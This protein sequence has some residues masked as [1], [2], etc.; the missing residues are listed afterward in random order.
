MD[1]KQT[2]EYIE[3]IYQLF[4]KEGINDSFFILNL[5]IYFLYLRRLDAL[6]TFDTSQKVS[7]FVDE[8]I[9]KCKWNY[10][11]GLDAYQFA[12]N[13]ITV[14]IPF[15]KQQVVGS[16]PLLF[17][18]Y[19]RVPKEKKVKDGSVYY[20]LFHLV[21]DLLNSCDGTIGESIPI[22]YL[23]YIYEELINHYHTT[24]DKGHLFVPHH[25]AR[26]MCELAD[27]KVE[28]SIYTPDLGTGDLLV[29]AYNT[30]VSNNL[31]EGSKD[32]DE[33][34]F[35][36]G[37]VSN[38]LLTREQLNNLVLEGNQT[39]DE[40]MFL[41]VMNIY[42]HGI[43]LVHN[44]TTQNLL[45]SDFDPV[46]RKYTKIIA[47]PLIG[48]LLKGQ[49]VDKELK[50]RVG[51]NKSA[52]YIDRCL[53]QLGEGGRLVF[54]TPEGFLF[55]HDSK[56]S[57]YREHLLDSYT[58]EAVISLPNGVLPNTSIKTSIL[59]ISKKSCPPNGTV[60]LCELKNDGYSLNAK[61]LRNSES[62][63]PLLID[64]FKNRAEESN[65]LMDCFKVSQIEMRRHQAAWVVNFY[66][67]YHKPNVEYK[68]PQDI[69]SELKKMEKGIILELDN[70]SN[71][72]IS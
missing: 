45:S 43:N 41:T 56:T 48:S 44:F 57:R 28:D 52:M 54:L 64:N 72:L 71:L 6:G 1:R 61:R 31:S 29:T 19:N 55:A 25:I 60:W 12:D 37:E 7:N 2:K 67:E 18:F 4:W 30:I 69:I 65:A 70:L 40:D 63:L 8:S 35:V 23:G 39:S 16:Y 5:T 11:K 15:L 46:S 24:R 20:E 50:E 21:D 32:K 36:V 13:Y 38:S 53:E 34:G 22:G 3:R 14:V 27:L 51:N 49:D 66:N 42:F 26:L 68:N 33:D 47:A 10:L 17:F 62:P 9:G 59:V 58:L